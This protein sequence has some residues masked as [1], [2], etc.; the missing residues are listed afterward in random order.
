MVLLW[1]AASGVNL[2]VYPNKRPHSHHHHHYVHIT[3]IVIYTTRFKDPF[4]LQMFMYPHISS[5]RRE[6][7]SL[8]F[9]DSRKLFSFTF[10]GFQVGGERNMKQRIPIN[11]IT[12]KLVLKSM[13]ASCSTGPFFADHYSHRFE[14]TQLK[15]RQEKWLPVKISCI[16]W[17]E[18]CKKKKLIKNRNG[19]FCQKFLIFLKSL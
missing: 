6:L 14:K 8:S 1:R 19:I 10:L 16:I 2:E 17:N 13:Y 11:S 9:Q 3:L 12:S 4:A 15:F 7:F 18:I 5:R